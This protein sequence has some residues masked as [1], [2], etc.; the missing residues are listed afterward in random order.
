MEHEV[1]FEVKQEALA[2]VKDA[3]IEA[4]FD[5]CRS[6]LTEVMTPYATMVVTEDSIPQAKADRAKI[7]KIGDQI[8]TAR[9]AVKKIYTEPL[10][11][12]EARCKELTAIC[13]T[14]SGNID[15]QVKAFEQREREEKL[16]RIEDYYRETVPDALRAALPFAKVSRKEWGNKG[17]SEETAMAE[18]DEAVKTTGA[19]IDAIRNLP[20]KNTAYLM[21][22]YEHGMTLAQ[23]IAKNNELIQRT[24]FETERKRMLE[25]QQREREEA[26]RKRREAVE[27][28]IAAAM[29]QT[30]AEAA[31]EPVKHQEKIYSLAFVAEGTQ[32]QLMSLR[33]FC[34]KAGITLR[35]YEG[36]G[37]AENVH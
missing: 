8:D 6:A 27:K 12:F 9:K 21:D 34:R 13:D 37:G 33:E 24:E 29:P 22:L 11:Q 36:A 25:A 32:E 26:D 19:E 10:A 23:V 28:A 1:Q 15:R 20:G 4:N 35:R 17:Y 31:P 18:I 16:A 5:E 3:K 2:L 7:R 14:A 30:K